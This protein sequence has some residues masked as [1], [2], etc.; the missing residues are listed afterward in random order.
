MF[1]C[2]ARAGELRARGS[3]TKNL[4]SAE[5]VKR[6]FAGRIGALAE[7][8]GAVKSESDVRVDGVETSR[9][10]FPMLDVVERRTMKV[11]RCDLILF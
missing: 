10:Q 4:P 7:H 8:R 3:N 2:G 1:Y 5:V 11:T 9:D 6:D